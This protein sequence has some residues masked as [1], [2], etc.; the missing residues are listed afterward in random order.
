MASRQAYVGSISLVWRQ[1][2]PPHSWNMGGVDMQAL[3]A[4]AA[5]RQIRMVL[6]FMKS[7]PMEHV[8]IIEM[9]IGPSVEGRAENAGT[10]T[11]YL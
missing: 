7:T 5:T 2:L 11:A 4:N 6:A 1:L 8:L 9:V 10:A 3:N